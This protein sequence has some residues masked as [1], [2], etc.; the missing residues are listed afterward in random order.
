M[1]HA[2]LRPL[3]LSAALHLLAISAGDFLIRQSAL[4]T[5]IARSHRISLRLNAPANR[6]PESPVITPTLQPPGDTT[7]RPSKSPAMPHPTGPESSTPSAPAATETDDQLEYRP[8]SLVANGPSDI[9][10]PE[11]LVVRGEFRL[12]ITVDRDGRPIA[13]RTLHS[14]LPPVIE[15]LVIAQFLRAQYQPALRNGIP[16]TATLE[17]VI[18]V[19]PSE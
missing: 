7:P 1:R 3:L 18:A 8:P 19:S 16:V 13:V 10:F 11:N 5:P 6:P 12:E 15:R 17:I 9:Q 4:Q 2:L 14:S